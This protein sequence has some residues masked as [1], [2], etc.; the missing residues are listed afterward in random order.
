M[1][2]ASDSRGEDRAPGRR[3]DRSA[4]VY[5]GT[6]EGRPYR[7]TDSGGSWARTAIAEVG[8]DTVTAPAIDP[9]D[10]SVVYAG[11]DTSETGASYA[12]G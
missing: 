2:A 8:R 3:S 10:K 5:A 7:S 6:S 1:G 4:T 9:A 11:A 12:F